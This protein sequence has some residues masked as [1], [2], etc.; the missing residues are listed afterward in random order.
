MS[1]TAL[2]ERTLHPEEA[3]ERDD[4]RDQRAEPAQDEGEQRADD[5]DRHIDDERDR[6]QVPP[7][8]LVVPPRLADHA[9]G[10]THRPTLRELATPGPLEFRDPARIGS[11]DG[12]CRRDRGR[13]R[14][15]RASSEAERERLARVAADITPRAR[16]VRRARGRRARAV[17]RARG[18]I[19]AVKLVD[20]IERV[21][22]EREPA[23]SSAR[24]RSRS[25][26]SS[27]SASGG[28]SR[29]A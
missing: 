14:S 23:T 3:D 19:E 13:S 8:R 4:R 18:P 25:G 21:V 10:R 29:R 12:D 11:P 9:F 26:R 16:R 6:E 20:G 2:T 1:S 15:S 28:P 7:V 17:R 27:P 5:R 22:G 24:C